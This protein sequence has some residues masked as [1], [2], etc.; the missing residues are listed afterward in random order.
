MSGFPSRPYK[1]YNKIQHYD[2]GTRNGSAVIPQLLGIEP[3]PGM[4]YAELWI[5]AHPNAPS[6]I[7]IDGNRVRLDRAT[8]LFPLDILGDD[9]SRKFSRKFP[10]LLKI[11]SAA[12]SLSIQAHPNKEQAV[13]LHKRN[14][15]LY[16]DDNHKPEI[17]IAL[18]SLRAIVGF[19]P[20]AEIVKSIRTIPELR[21]LVGE[22]LIQRVQDPANESALPEAIRDLYATIMHE[23]ENSERLSRCIGRIRD[24][25]AN[26]VD[27]SPQGSEF[28]KQYELYGSDVGLLSLFFF[29]MVD[30]K[31]G[32]AIFTDAGVPHAYLEGNIVEC[33]ANSDNV[34]R[35]GLTGKFKD[36]ETL[37]N[38]IKYDFAPCRIINGS[39]NRNKLT[40]ATNADEFCVSRFPTAGLLDESC[41]TNNKPIV[42]LV[43]AGSFNVTWNYA[44]TNG[45]ENYSKGEALLIPASLPE[46]R[47]TSTESADLFEVTVP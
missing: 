34:V 30:L 4:P 20:G 44:G 22:G 33:M 32:Q 3:E 45:S 19:K 12:R 8:E 47:I 2:W 7:E 27:L 35:A 11:L 36:V 31:R 39:N 13:R 29:N 6:E 38:I 17:A 25:L 1:L 46:F 14:P 26:E 16:T 18:D 15:D 42:Y 24:R 5:G 23:S 40:Y 9:I 37:L 41:R 21:E 43:V 28:L 10:F